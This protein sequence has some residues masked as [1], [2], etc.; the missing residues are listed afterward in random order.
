MK[1]LIY[2]GLVVAGFV[3]TSLTAQTYI[4]DHVNGPIT[5]RPVRILQTNSAGDDVFVFDPS[6]GG[7][8]VE[9]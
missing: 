5:D 7:G 4:S 9:G 2:C 6:P 3:S 1:K 8:E